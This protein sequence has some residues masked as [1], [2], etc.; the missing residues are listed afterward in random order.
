MERLATA[1]V[2]C[3]LD[4]AY[5]LG[6]RESPQVV[7]DRLVELIPC[8]NAVHFEQMR[9]AVAVSG[10]LVFPA[11]VAEAASAFALQRPTAAERLTPGDGAVRLSDR[12]TRSELD[13]LDFYQHAMR[14][15]GVEDELMILFPTGGKLAGFSFLRERPFTERERTMLELLTPHLARAPNGEA[16]ADPLLT[17]REWEILSWV[18]GG[19]TNKEIA[20]SLLVTPSTVRKHLENVFEKLGVHTRTAAVARAFRTTSGRAR[21]GE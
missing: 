14:P 21:R 18:A 9:G 12:M 8:A 11:A 17:E 4:V 20:A 2:R 10:D 15:L 6:A 1:D 19:K 3:L 5:D 13:R 7:L 16:H